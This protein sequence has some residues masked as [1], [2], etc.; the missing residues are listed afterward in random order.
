MCESFF[1]TLECEL[2]ARMRFETHKQAQCEIFSFIEGWYNS[3]RRHSS[4]GYRSPINFEYAYAEQNRTSSISELPTA[5]RRH[6]R[7]RRPAARPW[8]TRSATSNGGKPPMQNST[9]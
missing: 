7:N 2:F 4:I 9:A 5:D 1:A 6:G 3:H 8:T